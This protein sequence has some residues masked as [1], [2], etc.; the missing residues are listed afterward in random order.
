MFSLNRRANGL[1]LQVSVISA[2]MNSTNFQ[3]IY[4]ICDFSFCSQLWSRICSHLASRSSG[5]AGLRRERV[6]LRISRTRQC[7]L[8]RATFLANMCEPRRNKAKPLIPIGRQFRRCW[9]LVSGP[10]SVGPNWEFARQC[11]SFSRAAFQLLGQ[12]GK[13]EMEKQRASIWEKKECR[14]RNKKKREKRREEG[15]KKEEQGIEKK[16]SNNIREREKEEKKGKER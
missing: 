14:K 3:Q 10:P 8:E 16:Q 9:L 4:V 13:R 5:A 11:F 6:W 2:F 7:A 1:H 15:I 12:K